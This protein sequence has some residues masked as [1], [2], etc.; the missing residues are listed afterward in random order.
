MRTNAVEE[1]ERGEALTPQTCQ[2]VFFS[3]LLYSYIKQSETGA[4]RALQRPQCGLVAR[5]SVFVLLYSYSK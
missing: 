1:E 5:V 4:F 2:Y 3:N